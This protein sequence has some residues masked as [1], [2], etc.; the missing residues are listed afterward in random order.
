MRTEPCKQCGNFDFYEKGNFSY[1]RPC[2]AEAQKRYAQNKRMGLSYEQEKSA[3]KPLARRRFSGRTSVKYCPRGHS[4][5]GDNVRYEEYKGRMQIRCKACE[6]D[7]KRV[8]Y[9]LRAEPNPLRL[10]D[11]LDG[12]QGTC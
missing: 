9:G 10:S 4:Y 12:E 3:T 5:S 11:L 7:A 6:R 2:H 1:C 8:R